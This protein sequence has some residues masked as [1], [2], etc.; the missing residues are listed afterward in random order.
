MANRLKLDKM[1]KDTLGTNNVYFQ[2]PPSLIMKFP[3]IVYERVRINT[4]FADNN[5]YQ[6]THVYQVT[7]IDSNPDSDVPQKIAELPMCVFE[8]EFVNSNKYHN[9][10]RIVN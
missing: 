7:Y 9:V 4:E 10:F 6:L 3:C 5:P 2:P 1:L 8:R